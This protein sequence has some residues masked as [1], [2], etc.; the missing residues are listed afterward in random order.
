MLTAEIVL[1]FFAVHRRL[2]FDG[3]RIYIIT[4]PG[5]SCRALPCRKDISQNVAT[6]FMDVFV[7][8]DEG[9]ACSWFVIGFIRLNPIATPLFSML[10]LV[11]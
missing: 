9:A 5:E 6:A 2:D 11:I 7:A 4:F 10:V 1:R 3:I 8:A